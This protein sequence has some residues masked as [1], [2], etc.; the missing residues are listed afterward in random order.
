MSGVVVLI[1]KT[2]ESR[3]TEDDPRGQDEVSLRIFAA[4]PMRGHVPTSEVSTH[5]SLRTHEHT[6]LV[7]DT[8]ICDAKFIRREPGA[9]RLRG[10]ATA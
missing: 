2:N 8:R 10:R 9:H 7:Y 5:D 4:Y 3:Y 6:T 1:H